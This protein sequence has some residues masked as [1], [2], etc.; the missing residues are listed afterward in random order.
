MSQAPE[1]HEAISHDPKRPSAVGAM[2]RFNDDPATQATK[3]KDWDAELTSLGCPRI[4][5][6]CRSDSIL[7]NGWIYYIFIYIFQKSSSLL[8]SPVHYTGCHGAR[9]KHGPA[10]CKYCLSIKRSNHQHT[11]NTSK[12]TVTQSILII[13]N[14]INPCKSICELKHDTNLKYQ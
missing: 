4:T 3:K 12:H 6:E 7:Q 13:M 10:W 2:S 8:F 14:H 5:G 1:L 9:F 11:R